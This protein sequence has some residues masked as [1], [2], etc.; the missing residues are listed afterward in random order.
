M[1]VQR[2]ENGVQGGTFAGARGPGDQDDAVR[3]VNQPF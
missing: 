2:R 1:A 3:A